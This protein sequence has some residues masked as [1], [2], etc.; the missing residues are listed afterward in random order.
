MSTT[1]PTAD[2][3]DLAVS[4]ARDAVR[5]Q[6]PEEAAL[7][8]G[9]AAAYRRDPRTFAVGRRRDDP[10]A[11]GA[12]E[13]SMLTPIALSVASTVASMVVGAAR[14]EVQ[15][16]VEGPV[17]R[18]VRRLLRR[19]APAPVPAAQPGLVDVRQAAV[20]Q[21]L[22]FDLPPERA[23]ALADAVVGRLVVPA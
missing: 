17:R 22:R 15:A 2:P 8:D 19:P 21:A 1:E 14:S 3:R 4:L 16:A 12:A 18:F 23:A 6:A 20:D 10:L 7:F 11:F 13:L 5:E 9:L